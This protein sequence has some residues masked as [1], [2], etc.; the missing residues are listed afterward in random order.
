[1]W[2]S[3]A[4]GEASTQC[5]LQNKVIALGQLLRGSTGSRRRSEVST[6]HAGLVGWLVAG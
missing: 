1:M 3:Q 6:E 2:G 5:H 4:T